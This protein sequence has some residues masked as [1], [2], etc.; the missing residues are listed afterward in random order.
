MSTDMNGAARCVVGVVVCVMLTLGLGGC[1]PS[2]VT[3]NFGDESTLKRAVV[4][5]VRAP[6]GDDGESGGR[7]DIAVIDVRG[8]ILDSPAPALFGSQ[9]NPTAELAARLRVAGEDDDVKAVVLR[10]NTPGGGVTASETMHAIVRRFRQ[11]TGKPVIIS[12]GDVCASGGYYLSTAGDYV[13]AQ[14]T[15]ITGSIGV[16]IPTVNFSE[17]MRRIGIVSRSIKSGAN[18]DLANPLE[19]MR[20]SQYAVLQQMVDEFYAR[21]KALVV[22]SRQSPA[23]VRTASGQTLARAALDMSR[24]DELTDGRVLS[25]TQAVRAG[26]ADVEGDLIDAIHIARRMAGLSQARVV[27]F[28]RSSATPTTVYASTEQD[29]GVH[30]PGG[31]TGGGDLHLLSLYLSPGPDQLSTG[32]AYYLWVAGK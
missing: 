27:R 13:V 28:H 10:M 16:I 17:G 31:N 3:L 29:A 4:D 19:G 26:L 21:F 7:G 15:G 6:A 11:S 32:G 8:V 20:D 9:A 1:L 12:M 22:A 23:V 24:V 2:S 25:G 14:P 30:T 5:E 18:K